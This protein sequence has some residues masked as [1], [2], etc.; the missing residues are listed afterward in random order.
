MKKIPLKELDAILQEVSTQLEPVVKAEV[1]RAAEKLSKAIPGEST[2]DEVPKDDSAT[3]EASDDKAT[4][5]PPKDDAPPADKAPDAPADGPPALEAPVDGPP[6][7]DGLTDPAADGDIDSPE[8]LQAA[9][10]TLPLDELQVHYLA[11]R[12]AMMAAMPQ[13]APAPEAPIA[14]LPAAVA[15]PAAP[16]LAPPMAP[17]VAPPAVPPMAD[18]TLK[19]EMPAD[20]NGSV[21]AVKKSEKLIEDLNKKVTEQTAV[22]AELIDLSAALKRHAE[23]PI[24][25]SAVS[26]SEVRRATG[27]APSAATVDLASL[28]KSEMK[29]L[30]RKTV[31]KNLS[32]NDRTRMHDFISGKYEDVESV[33]DL[34]AA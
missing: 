6:V 13:A 28:S 20:P 23:R 17:P 2:T 7:D 1:L 22:I 10:S 25:K 15:P 34:L 4:A 27:A 8:A 29:V 16:P 19:A 12:A 9:Y 33:K 26:L 24:R 21:S 18:P 14:A 32:V 31:E 30:V 5:P 3:K 11:I